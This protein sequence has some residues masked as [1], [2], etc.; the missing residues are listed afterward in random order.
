MT[1]GVRAKKEENECFFWFNYNQDFRIPHQLLAND[2]QCPCDT[3][4]LRFDPRFAI[5][6]FDMKNRILCYASVLVEQNAVIY[7]ICNSIVILQ[8]HEMLFL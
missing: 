2:I 4:L 1:E 6:R 7:I 3:R 5:S 8:F